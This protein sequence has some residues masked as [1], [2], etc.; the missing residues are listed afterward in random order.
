MFLQHPMI[1]ILHPVYRIHSDKWLA[2]RPL[3]FGGIA[4]SNEK[5]TI[6]EYNSV[7]TLPAPHAEPLLPE[8]N[9]MHRKRT[10][11]TG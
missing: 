2:K 6:T 11:C 4:P 1:Q 3:S 10:P 7:D 5:R 8:E 9:T